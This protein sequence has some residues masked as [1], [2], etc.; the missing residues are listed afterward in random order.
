MRPL[1]RPM[2]RNGG[3]IKEG[4]MSG[5]QDR[6]GYSLGS[7]VGGFFTN[8]FKKPAA[9]A[10]GTTVASQAAKKPSV[11]S[12][13]G[14]KLKE[15]FTGSTKTIEK[16]GPTIV[17]PGGNVYSKGYPGGKVGSQTIGPGTATTTGN[18]QP[19]TPGGPTNPNI[20]AAAQRVLVPITTGGGKVLSAAKPYSTAITIGG[21]GAY[22]L[23]NDDGTQK[24]IEQIKS[25]TGAS[26]TEIASAINEANKGGGEGGVN[27]DAEIEANRKRY[28]KLMGIDKMNKDA[29]YNTLIDASNQIREGG[30]I[31]DQL[32]SGSLASGVINALSKNLDKSVDLKKQIDAAILKGEI[33]KDINKQKD[34]LDAEYK[35][36]VIDKAKSDMAG[37]TM[38]QIINDRKA[39]GIVTS[40]Q[41][42]FKLAV[43]T[44]NASNIK[45]IISDK[46]VSNYFKDNPT[47]TA[48]DFFQEEVVL[49]LAEE[50]KSVT[51]GD[52]IVGENILRVTADGGIQF[53]F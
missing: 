52:Y 27:R 43:Q 7:K 1:N 28:Y 18:L 3:P 12:A 42:L 14:S 40:G 36:T 49:K 10:T 33:T 41:D 15:L 2:F 31:K 16:Q 34:Q 30:T 8:L 29:V 39:K 6:P 21:I 50:G 24:T 37:G 4:I 22:S 51:P 25:E 46:A 23:L 48:A 35:R 20:Y 38:N 45:E 26:E 5:M 44:G 9:Q 17:K 11:V 47:K 32:K 19:F 53:V 13:A